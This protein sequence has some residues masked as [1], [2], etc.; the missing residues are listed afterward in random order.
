M[1][2]IDFPK[3]LSLEFAASLIPTKNATVSYASQSHDDLY[4]GGNLDNSIDLAG[5]ASALNDDRSQGSGGSQ[6]DLLA[7]FGA[8][9]GG[10]SASRPPLT[11]GNTAMSMPRL[12]KQKTGGIEAAGSFMS[13]NGKSAL[14][15]LSPIE[16]TTPM[17]ARTP[18]PKTPKTHFSGNA[19]DSFD[20]F[21]FDDDSNGGS[22]KQQEL[23][24]IDFFRV[25]SLCE[26]RLPRASID[27]KV[28]R[29][30]VVK[31]R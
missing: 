12:V 19:S 6:S 10:G 28:L 4:L 22:M 24:N 27:I 26:L 2:N 17:K 1:T 9:G 16:A 8:V 15:I 25:C 23:K 21:D 30:H 31:L 3:E 14:N 7:E 18:A 5:G 20:D 13:G 11:R 29:K